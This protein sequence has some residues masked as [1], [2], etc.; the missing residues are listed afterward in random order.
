MK[1]LRRYS[2]TVAD[3]RGHGGECMEHSS[4][5]RYVEYSSHKNVV[6]GLER[7]IGQLLI[8]RKQFEV[9]EDV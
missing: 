1:Q 4:K 6:E 2:C 7:R 5:G 3:K 9:G 8:S